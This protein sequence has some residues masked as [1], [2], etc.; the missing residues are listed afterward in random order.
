MKLIKKR[1][2]KLAA[3]ALIAISFSLTIAAQSTD[4]SFP[5]AVTTNEITGTIKARDIGDSRLTSYF[6]TFD[7]GQG[8]V[9]I[10]VVTKNFNGDIDVFAADGLRPLTKIVVYADAENETGRLVYLRKPERLILRV[11][12][13]SPNDDPA[14]FRIKFAGSF[15]A[16]AEQKTQD[17]PTIARREVEVESG[18][19][20]NSVGTI[21]EV[22]PKPQPTPKATPEAK[23][24][25]A[26][27]DKPI[28]S[29]PVRKEST[30]PP[31]P[32]TAKVKKPASAPKTKEKPSLET[33]AAKK[34][35]VKKSEETAKKES[36][37]EKKPAKKN[38]SPEVK[39]VL[40]K[41]SKPKKEIVAKTP[42]E[43]AL[44]EP[45]IPDPMTNF[46]LVVQLKDGKTIERPMKEVTKFSVDKGI[47]TV[48]ATDGSTI[49]Y[50]MGDVAKVTIE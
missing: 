4:Q 32:K 42:K 9:F 35:P 50:S 48:T 31:A 43:P 12:G 14:T 16:L 19:R 18:V 7:G 41:S 34:T 10:N 49:I 11:E 40:K 5:T 44:P 22:I 24:T 17:T 37:L 29:E 8:D 33:T 25:V 38:E 28:E 13:R 36:T 23:E 1:I 15:I 39:T 30:K 6:Y 2:L 26:T 3:S 45:T 27:A 21:V 46:R 20:V 47:L